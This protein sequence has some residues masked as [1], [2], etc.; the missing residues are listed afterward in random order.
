MLAVHMAINPNIETKVRAWT[1]PVVKSIVVYPLL[2]RE[3][4][5]HVPLHIFL[6]V[7][8][9]SGARTVPLHTCFLCRA[10]IQCLWCTDALLAMCSCMIAG[11]LRSASADST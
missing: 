8:G 5:I 2:T 9:T 7:F 11:S 1:G 4:Y 6:F 10:L 3:S